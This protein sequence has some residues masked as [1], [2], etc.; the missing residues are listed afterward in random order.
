MKKKVE[1]EKV[2]ITC[3]VCGKKMRMIK[4]KSLDFKGMLCQKCSMHTEKADN[5]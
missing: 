1:Y 2:T 4:H 3:A 5:D